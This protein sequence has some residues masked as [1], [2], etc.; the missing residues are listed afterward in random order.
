M[1]PWTRH[2]RLSWFWGKAPARRAMDTAAIEDQE[3]EDD[4]KDTGDDRSR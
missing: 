4:R 2:K 3:A 1:K